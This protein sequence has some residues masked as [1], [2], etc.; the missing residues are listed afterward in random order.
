M[1][2]IFIALFG[3]LYWAFKLGN[4]RAKSNEADR[5]IT[6]WR[7]RNDRWQSSVLDEE[8]NAKTMA[9]VETEE[10]FQELKDKALKVLRQ[11]PGLEYADIQ[12][13]ISSA[14]KHTVRFIEMVNHGKLPHGDESWLSGSLWSCLDL[15][16]SKKAK[17]EF[18]R[19]VEKTMQQ[20]G[21]SDARLYYNIVGY[22]AEFEWE[23]HMD[24][25]E[26]A[27]SVNDP[28]LENII[29]GESAEVI[30][31]RNAPKI[32]AKQRK[33]SYDKWTAEVNGGEMQAFLELEFDGDHWQSIRE[34]TMQFLRKFPGLELADYWFSNKDYH[35]NCRGLIFLIEMVKKGKL[36][37]DCWCGI[38]E[39]YLDTTVDIYPSRATKIAF[40]QWV[41]QTLKA[42]GV[43]DAELYYVPTNNPKFR[44]KTSIHDFENAIRI[45]DSNLPLSMVGE[46]DEL[47]AARNK[48]LFQQKV[49]QHK[50]QG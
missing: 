11:L 6:D 23:Q 40:M 36:P 25:F 1:W 43:T 4:D 28:N 2:A 49:Q 20:H 14:A 29:H 41:E 39:N 17:A 7:E 44:W 42:N 30:E 45:T 22:D 38:P 35:R 33:K 27:T 26:N 15:E 34:T 31:N 3:G 5:R 12:G 48:S 19:W 9:M 16:F 50:E 46:S 47:I 10:G 8:L 32:M 21:Q 13:R 18:V 37:I 24:T